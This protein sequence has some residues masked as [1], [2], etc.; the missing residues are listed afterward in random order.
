MLRLRPSELTLTPEDVEDTFRRLAHRQAARASAVAAARGYGRQGRPVIRC[1]PQRS[2]RHATTGPG[3]IS[4]YQNQPQQAIIT[5]DNEDVHDD[6]GH[7]APRGIRRDSLV[8]DTSHM[9][10]LRSE[11]PTFSSALR[12]MKLPFRP[13]LGNTQDRRHETSDQGEPAS[14]ST[15]PGSL[16][17]AAFG[18]TE[19][20]HTSQTQNSGSSFCPLSPPES[21]SDLRGG[22]GSDSPSRHHTHR[23]VPDAGRPSS[24]LRQA[25]RL[26]SPL[27]SKHTPDPVKTIVTPTRNQPMRRLQGYFKS[28]LVE[29]YGISYHFRESIVYPQSE[30][31]PRRGRK[32]VHGRSLSSGN[33]P[34][35]SLLI[36]RPEATDTS[37]ES[38]FGPTRAV[39]R[40]SESETAQTRRGWP[41]T[42]DHDLSSTPQLVR[43]MV[44]SR[45]MHRQ[46]SSE[47]SAA[48]ASFS[49]YGSLP[50]GSRHSS[51]GMSGTAQFPHTQYDGSTLSREV[52]SAVNH[53]VRSLG[54]SANSLLSSS[55]ARG[56]IASP[57][58]RAGYSPLPSSPY[59]RTQG[60]RATSQNSPATS[61]TDFIQEYPDATEAAA[62][63]LRSPLDEY[64]EQYQRLTGDQHSRESMPHYFPHFQPAAYNPSGSRRGSTGEAYRSPYP[65][66]PTMDN[67]ERRQPGAQSTQQNRSQHHA[68][69]ANQRSSQNNPVTSPLINTR[70]S[71]GQVQTQRAAY[72]LLQNASRA[73][74]T[75]SPRASAGAPVRSGVAPSTIPPRDVSNRERVQGPRQMPS[76]SAN[77][78]QEGTL[79]SGSPPL[80]PG[81]QNSSRALPQSTGLDGTLGVPQPSGYRPTSHYREDTPN[82]QTRTQRQVSTTALPS[83]HLH[84]SR[85]SPL[86][87]LALDHGSGVTSRRSRSP[88]VRASTTA[89]THRRV[90]AHQRD[91]ENSA[92]AEISAMRQEE[93]AVTTRYG[94]NGQQETMD[95]TPPRIGRFEQA[96]FE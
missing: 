10:T 40:T 7:H 44:G 84:P 25:H 63:N 67:Q 94:E 89:R 29:P 71:R 72:E 31:R 64:S 21:H 56:S 74:Q 93:A 76:Q 52:G 92:E 46:S 9:Q 47:V 90:P 61:Q 22:A 17:H 20:A 73:M 85:D 6:V 16:P 88:L 95:E 78:R 48:S 57:D 27:P 34:P 36:P 23:E 87:A 14:I 18:D 55:N 33:V 12:S 8:T 96:M 81:N 83:L 75:I 91:Q 68:T 39:R 70:S 69:R 19:V 86:T 37:D 32:P 5:V 41:S 79:M 50:S 35:F 11:Y 80:R 49:Y 77:R 65:P 45:H 30:P 24:P 15:T 28:P 62:R 53:R 13:G 4:L 82:S 26:K 3:D 43:T 2:V 51:S 58:F 59:A 60:E 54:V 1:G 38:A 42:S 66:M